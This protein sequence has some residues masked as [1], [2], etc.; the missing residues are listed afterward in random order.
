M[1]TETAMGKRVVVLYRRS[2]LSQ[3]VEGLLK[4]RTDLEVIGVDLDHEGAATQVE[5]AHPECIIV[6]DADLPDSWSHLSF[7]LW[8][9][10]P[11]I[12]FIYLNMSQN[13]AEVVGGRRVVVNS[14][15]DLVRA[16]GHR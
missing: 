13:S 4:G 10:N 5:Q 15:K 11:R 8:R 6:D 1:K 9:E 16:L 3:T 14:V 2:L 12:K 7:H